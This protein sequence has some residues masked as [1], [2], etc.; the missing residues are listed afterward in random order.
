M[1][2][3]LPVPSS[4]AVATRLGP[5]RPVA[6][7]ASP[8]APVEERRQRRL[9][10]AGRRAEA[11]ERQCA[12]D[13]GAG[14]AEDRR[15]A[16][17]SCVDWYADAGLIGRCGHKQVLAYLKPCPA[18]VVYPRSTV[19]RVLSKV[20]TWGPG[21]LQRGPLHGPRR[22]RG[23]GLGARRAGG[24][25]DAFPGRVGGASGAEGIQD[26]R[27][28]VRT[29]LLRSPIDFSDAQ[30]NER[31]KGVG[32]RA[33]K[34]EGRASPSGQALRAHAG[35][36]WFHDLAKARKGEISWRQASPAAG[37]RAVRRRPQG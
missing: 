11:H 8:E 16:G 33:I 21:G 36:L 32:K 14:Q 13:T 4:R 2:L 34:R 9:P 24:E 27:Q 29:P 19:A 25:L 17:L 12:E 37:P 23:R 30:E 5:P 31:V 22:R 26:A 3:V 35:R 20:D 15:S 10:V 28:A 1:T 7:A 6:G 18:R